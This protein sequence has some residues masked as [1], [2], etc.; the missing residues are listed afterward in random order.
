[1][2]IKK[3]FAKKALNYNR[4]LGRAI[5]DTP[6]P[7]IVFGLAGL[8]VAFGGGWAIDAYKPLENQPQMGQEASIQQHQSAL[9]Q[10]QE[11]RDALRTVQGD[12][13]FTPQLLNSIIEAPENQANNDDGAERLKD[14]YNRMLNA[15]VGSVH[16]DSRLN[17]AD[18]QKLLTDFESA[19]GAVDK[20]TSFAALDYN[21]LY[22]A[23]TWAEK[24]GQDGNE[25]QQAQA[26]NE[27][28]DKTREW[29]VFLG[30]GIGTFI[31]PWLLMLLIAIPGGTLRRWEKET[32]KPKKTGKYTH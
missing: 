22:E 8:T 27:R 14:D 19:H 12:D 6:L 23:R 20:V 28:A 2:G 9:T 10:L 7:I 18:A 30:G 24:H 17:E 29:G 4:S 3:S 1:M 32:P 31:G 21:D 13:H 15:F 11:T 5:D 25:L 16:I 26:I